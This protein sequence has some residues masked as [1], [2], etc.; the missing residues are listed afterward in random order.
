[1]AKRP[2]VAVTVVGIYQ[3][4]RIAGPAHSLALGSDQRRD[5]RLK[6][7]LCVAEGNA[8]GTHTALISSPEGVFNC[9]PA[10]WFEVPQQGTWICGSTSEGD[11]PGY[12]DLGLQ[13]AHTF[14]SLN[15]RRDPIILGFVNRPVHFRNH[16]PPPVMA[17]TVINKIVRNMD[18]RNSTPIFWLREHKRQ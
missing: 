6:G 13:P 9:D 12:E 17:A 11:A 2:I 3:F 5:C 16:L 14:K 18:A 10:M 7:N 4:Q 1:M 8:L 15:D